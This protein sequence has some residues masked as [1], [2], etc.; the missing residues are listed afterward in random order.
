M[1]NALSQPQTIV[2]LGG[3]SEIGRAIVSSLASPQLETVVLARRSDTGTAGT[4]APIEGLDESVEVLTVPFDATDHAAHRAWFVEL[5]DRVGDL[6]VVVQAFG[7]LGPD[8]ASDP[9]EAAAQ[10]SEPDS[11]DTASRAALSNSSSV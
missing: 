5:A 8:A 7:Q 2:L 11:W 9:V 6:D 4:E 3:S 1:M 10:V